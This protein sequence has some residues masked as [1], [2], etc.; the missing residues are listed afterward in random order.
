MGIIQL[1]LPHSRIGN[2][3]ILLCFFMGGCD[4]FNKKINKK[5]ASINVIVNHWV[6]VLFF[7][8]PSQFLE[9]FGCDCLIVA[10]R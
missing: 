1:P 8:V 3:Y 2:S 5:N 6:N 9:P 7:L 4:L 10:S